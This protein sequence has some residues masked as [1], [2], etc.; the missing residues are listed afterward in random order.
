[1]KVLGVLN[2]KGGAGKT[3]TAVNAAAS[4]ALDGRRVLLVDAD[5]QGSALTWAAERTAPPLFTVVGLPKP[6]LH[7]DVPELAKDYDVVV[8]DGAPRTSDVARAAIMASDF[9]LIPVQPSPLDVWA[10]ADTVQLIA[11]ATVFKAHLKAAFAVNRRI[12]G[13]AIG[14]DVGEALAQYGLPVL[15]GGLSQRVLFAETF[16]RGLAV[17]E[18]A[19]FGD[20][21]R[22]VSALVQAVIT[23][24]KSERVAA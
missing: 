4:L 15:P 3:T 24:S 6:T 5:P 14:R 12:V 13:T 2:Q 8:I 9:I 18:V 22:E 23:A 10:A 11:E 7:R 21:G 1:M 19:P 20:A 16:A 17:P